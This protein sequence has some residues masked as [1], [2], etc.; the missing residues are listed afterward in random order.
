M[1]RPLYLFAPNLKRPSGPAFDA[2]M[3]IIEH[4]GA[5]GFAAT[6]YADHS[7]AGLDEQSAIRIVPYFTEPGRPSAA[8]SPGGRSPSRSRSG[9]RWPLISSLLGVARSY[10]LRDGT[11]ALL[12]LS[13]SPRALDFLT[14]VAKVLLF[15]LKCMGSLWRAALGM[16]SFVVDLPRAVKKLIFG[17]SVSVEP[18]S[19]L[20]AQLAALLDERAAEGPAV[21][22]V[23][24][25]DPSALDAAMDIELL[26]RS[27]PVSLKFVFLAEGWE[28]IELDS[29]IDPAMLGKRLTASAMAPHLDIYVDA[30]DGRD[31]LARLLGREVR[32]LSRLEGD[33]AATVDDAGLI[34]PTARPL[35]VVIRPNWLFCGSNMVFAN[36]IEYLTERGFYVLEVVVND[37]FL[38]ESTPA[39]AS[40]YF[41]STYRGSLADRTILLNMK[42]GLLPWFGVV[43][44]YGGCLLRSSLIMRAACL[45]MAEAPASLSRALARR[46]AEVVVVNHCFNMKIARKLFPES[47]LVLESHDIQA[48]Q[49]KLRSILAGETADQFDI[50]AARADELDL[51]GDASWV[52]SL[53][54]DETQYF[55]ESGKVPGVTTIHPYLVEPSDHRLEGAAN[56]DAAPTASAAD[57]VVAPGPIDVLL[58]S[59]QHAANIISMRWFLNKVFKPFLG[60]DA[61]RVTIVGNISKAVSAT[62]PNLRFT[63]QV[64][65]IQPY[66][67]AA[68]VIALPVT[69]GAGIPIKTLEALALGK[70]VVATSGALRGLSNG[71]ARALPAFDEAEAFA[72]EIHRLIA[73]PAEREERAQAG[74]SVADDAYSRSAY[75]QGWDS[76]IERLPV[77]GGGRRPTPGPGPR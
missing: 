42:V 66:Y 16:P 32:P 37:L 26:A 9:R 75:F 34:P 53:N 44:R 52:V 77:G 27:V 61:V 25:D 69:A 35:A 58:V 4:A 47:P 73:D 50:D 49:S 43:C 41:L 21:V 48:E 7:F 54:E 3:R 39:H 71:S 65:D 76:V 70:A 14:E 67:E 19:P 31:R 8:K 74:Q 30:P 63:G 10:H 28:G 45:E 55:M 11:Q 68:K 64:R 15:A 24:S 38:G 62:H 59:S 29:R 72:T 12:K 60:H 36:Q 17:P 1:S 20:A 5:L 46:R 13:F 23:L 51:M 56:P 40:H 22:V 2:A 57:P 18:F 6:A 33:L